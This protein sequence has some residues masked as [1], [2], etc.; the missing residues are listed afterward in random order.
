MLL[1]VN[2]SRTLVRY[3]DVVAGVKLVS[4]RQ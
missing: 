3:L 4:A 2:D 1:S